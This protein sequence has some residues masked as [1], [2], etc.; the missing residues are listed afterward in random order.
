M[1]LYGSVFKAPNQWEKKEADI[2]RMWVSVCVRE[3]GW[4]YCDITDPDSGGTV[5]TD[6]KPWSLLKKGGFKPDLEA[7]TDYRRPS[8]SA[9]ANKDLIDDLNVF[10]CL[11][12]TNLHPSPVQPNNNNLCHTSGRPRST[13]APTSSSLL[14]LLLRYAESS[15]N[16]SSRHTKLG[17]AGGPDGMPLLCLK[18]CKDQLAPPLNR[19]LEGV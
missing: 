15:W 3:C 8:P 18:N 6:V 1:T 14:K 11:K 2:R 10:Y 16:G 5:F 9:E 4:G 19:P 7:V 13:S 12:R 17:K